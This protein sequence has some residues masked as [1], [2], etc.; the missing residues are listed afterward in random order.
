MKLTILGAGTDASQLSG[1]PNRF[2]PGYL[3]EWNKH[4]LLLECSEGIRF[5]LEQIGVDYAEIKYLAISHSH[6]DHYALPQYLQSVWNKLNWSGKAIGHE[7][8]IY[9]PGQITDNFLAL[10]RML[11]PGEDLL[12][13]P[14]LI[15]KKMT[16][17]D[18]ISIGGGKL[19]V[20]QVDHGNNRLE[21]LAF[22]FETPEGVLVYS[23]D[24][25]DC[26]AI[27]KISRNADLFICECS[28]LNSQNNEP[29]PFGHLSAFKA[30]EIATEAKAK[31]MILVHYVGV[32]S[33]KALISECRR[34]GFEGKVKVGKDFQ[35]FKI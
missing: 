4:K 14:K 23:A 30:G 31:K 5:R 10:W 22:R 19:S 12:P 15:L 2:P 6:P 18:S 33:D 17:G 24:T 7:L 34:S 28:L 32:D 8:T 16:D 20:V 29:G 27:R 13:Q 25:R 26:P 1:I 35:V 9:A 21:V 11:R 3:I